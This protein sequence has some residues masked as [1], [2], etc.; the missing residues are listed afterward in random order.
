MC[1][2]KAQRGW[3]CVGNTRPGQARWFAVNLN[4]KN[5]PWAFSRGEPFRTIASLELFATLLCV[6][7]FGDLW[8]KGASGAVRLQGITDNLGNTFALTKLM[9]SKF[10]LV[11]ILA[12]LAAQLK[13]RGMALNLEWAPRDQNEEADALTNADYSSFDPA[14][15]IQVDVESVSWIVLPR[16]LSVA[17]SIYERVQALKAERPRLGTVAKAS[18]AVGGGSLRQRDPW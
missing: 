6:V 15:R 13:A 11:V 1:L 18:A 12:E 8:P 10:P 14:R 4:K 3:E 7:L 16:M 17:S 2:G 5:A 9:S